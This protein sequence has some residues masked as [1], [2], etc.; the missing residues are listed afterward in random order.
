MGESV[1]YAHLRFSKTPPGWSAA[2]RAQRAAPRAPGEADRS[3]ENLHLG[4]VGA[5]PAG[6]RA[7]QRREP[8]RSVWPLPLGLLAACLALLVTTIALGVCYWQE[9]QRLQQASHSHAAERHG[10]WQQGGTQEQRLGQAGKALVQAQEELA[11][12][13][14][15]LAQAWQEGNRS[16][17]ELHNR[18]TELQETKVQLGQ[19]QEQA[20]D[21]QQQLNKTESALAS[22]RPC[23]VT[24]C[25]PGT[26]VLHRGKCLFL[27]KEEKNW[28]DSKRECENNSSRLLILH[29]WDQTK[30]PSFLTNTDDL[31]WIGLQKDWRGK[32]KWIWINGTQY[33]E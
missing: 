16:Q 12:T 8:R 13:R 5:G 24:D 31:Y 26:W 7:Q 28:W 6:S 30:M 14:A 29:N 3:Y 23:Q 19:V 25:C 10:L 22:A 9:R 21:L 17:E 32:D 15:E 1:T 11:R 4:A 18:D 2:P 27:S 20:W 33:P